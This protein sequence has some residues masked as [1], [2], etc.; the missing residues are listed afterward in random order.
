MASCDLLLGS[1]QLIPV[2]TGVKQ[3]H[4]LVVVEL[5]LPHPCRRGPAPPFCCSRAPPPR[6]C[7]GGPAPPSCCSRAPPPC[8]LR[9]GPAPPN[10]SSC[11]PPCPSCNLL[12]GRSKHPSPPRNSYTGQS[13][14][15]S[16]LCSPWANRSRQP[17][18]TCRSPQVLC[19]FL[20]KAEQ[21]VKSSSPLCAV[22]E[23]VVASRVKFFVLRV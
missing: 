3:H 14:Q 4:H 22:L 16:S 20:E 21:A 7:M 2:H 6:P 5:L 18:L 17:G 12:T 10:C 8:S 11:Q 13:R 23:Q 1:R 9:E 19:A 15:P